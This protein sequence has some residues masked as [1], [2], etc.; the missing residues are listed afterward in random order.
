[1]MRR[2]KSF[3]HKREMLARAIRRDERSARTRK[4]G[5]TKEGLNERRRKST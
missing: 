1:M 5:K 2:R 4:A 3:E